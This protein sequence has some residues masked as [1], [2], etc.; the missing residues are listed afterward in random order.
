MAV[1]GAHPHPVAEAALFGLGQPH[2]KNAVVLVVASVS[3]LVLRG[4]VCPTVVLVPVGA[5]ARVVVLLANK[6]FN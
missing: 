6:A 5:A 2:G 1:A 3:V 4:A